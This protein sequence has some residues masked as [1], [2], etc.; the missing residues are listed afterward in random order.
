MVTILMM[1][2]KMAP[3]DCLRIKVKGSDFIVSVHDVTNKILFHDSNYIA[4]VV[5][6]PKFGNSS[7]YMR[8]VNLNFIR[9]SPEKPLI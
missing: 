7:I 4:D 3:K 9:I 1:S 5:I 6:W 8:D 2:A